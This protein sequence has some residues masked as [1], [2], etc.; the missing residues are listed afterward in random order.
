MSELTCGVS[1]CTY[2]KDTACCKG[3]IMVGGKHACESDSTCCES[4]HQRS[5]EPLSS[6]VS[7]PSHTISIDCEAVKC[8]H[9]TGY[10]CDSEHV[11][12]NGN[13]ACTCG[14]TV[15]ATFVER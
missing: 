7:R 8:Q 11:D 6:S 2:N 3:D 10:H 15:C 4:F 13:N 9:N 1:N 14:E 12:I 5:G